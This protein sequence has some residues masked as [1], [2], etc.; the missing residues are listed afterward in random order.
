MRL[1][2]LAWSQTVWSLSSS[3]SRA[4]KWLAF[5]LGM[6]R[7]SQRGNG[8][9]GSGVVGSSHSSATGA[10]F[11]ETAAAGQA[12]VAGMH[13][14]TLATQG[15][16]QMANDGRAD[17]SHSNRLAPFGYQTAHSGRLHGV[18]SNQAK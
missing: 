6:L 5:P 10:F 13:V 15:F 16:R 7:F 3:I 14:A 8:S 11:R 2:H 12:G 18:G 4:V 9:C 1:G 17:S